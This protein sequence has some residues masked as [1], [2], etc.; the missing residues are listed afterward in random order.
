MARKNINKQKNIAL[1]MSPLIITK[2]N[3]N[4]KMKNEDVAVFSRI[5]TKKHFKFTPIALEDVAPP[6][7]DIDPPSIGWI[8][9]GRAEDKLTVSIARSAHDCWWFEDS[10]EQKNH[11]PVLLFSKKVNALKSVRNHM[12]MRFARW[13]QDFDKEISKIE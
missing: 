11:G 7:S 9:D 6:S 1:K 2:N 5:L 4:N 12:E 8:V 3:E 13:L 10:P